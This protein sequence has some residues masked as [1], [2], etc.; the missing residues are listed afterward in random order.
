M[1]GPE[2]DDRAYFR[3]EWRCR[4]STEPPI[5]CG[6]GTIGR[7]TKADYS[8]ES[9]ALLKRSWQLSIFSAG[10]LQGASFLAAQFLRV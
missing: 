7:N 1:L 10:L 4:H 3:Q 5:Y 6:D 2:R 9:R 8:I